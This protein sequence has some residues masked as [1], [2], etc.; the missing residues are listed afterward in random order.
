MRFAFGSDRVVGIK[1]RFAFG[2]DLCCIEG[3]LLLAVTF[4]LIVVPVCFW[5]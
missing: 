4:V 5:Q 1:N 2:S 3:G